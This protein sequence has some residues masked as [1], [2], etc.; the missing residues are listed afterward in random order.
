MN[1]F[2]T[3]TDILDFAI[4]AE[5]RAIAFYTQLSRNASS[6]AMKTVFLEFAEEER[7][8][9]A[10]LQEFKTSGQISIPT[11]DVM[12]LKIAD[13]IVDDT[14]ITPEMSY[15]SAL[16]LAMKRE[17]AAYKLYTN[18]AVLAADEHTKSIFKELAQEEAKHKLRFEVEYDENV[19]R[20]N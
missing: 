16:L 9:K 4:A 19:L 7:G 10:K 15:E 6:E 20:E 17:K 8:H 18:L 12:S 5:Q 1:S 3:I 11:E 2:K 14:K 13:Y